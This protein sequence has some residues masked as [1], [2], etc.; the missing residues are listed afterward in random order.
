M[1][2]PP[3]SRERCARPTGRSAAPSSR[4]EPPRCGLWCSEQG[5]ERNGAMETLRVVSYLNHFF[6]QLGGE[7]KAGLG[8]Q[9]IT[10]AAGAARAVQ[11]ALGEA[12][13]VVATVVCGDNYVAEN[14]ERAVGELLALVRA[15]RPDLVIAGP[16]FLAGRYGVAC[17]AIRAAVH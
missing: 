13:T 16:A 4:S 7:E 17:G 10:G 2:W 14:I 12:G 15:Q 3:S 8:P 1:I 9:V 11:Q 6:G 5:A